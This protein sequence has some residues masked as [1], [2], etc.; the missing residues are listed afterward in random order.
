VPFPT[1]RKESWWAGEEAEARVSECDSGDG[2]HVCPPGLTSLHPGVGGGGDAVP[3]TCWG[4]E[5]SA[6]HFKDE[7]TKA[8]GEFLSC[9]E[10]GIL[11]VLTDLWSVD[12][13]STCISTPPSSRE[14][15][16]NSARWAHFGFCFFQNAKCCSAASAVNK[17]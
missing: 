7:E 6:P 10:Q 3:V 13:L 14:D 17:Y 15:P 4:K 2:L 5:C 1:L 11:P 8:L 16:L 9:M 12:W